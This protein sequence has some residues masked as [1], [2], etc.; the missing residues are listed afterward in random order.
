MKITIKN[1]HEYLWGGTDIIIYSTGLYA[2]PSASSFTCEID[3]DGDRRY[4]LTKISSLH[5]NNQYNSKRS[6]YKACREI[7]LEVKK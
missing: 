7:I 4:P 3:K 2:V 6:H 5:F 1:L